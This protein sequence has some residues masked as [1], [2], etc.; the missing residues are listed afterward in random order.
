MKTCP[1]NLEGLFADNAFRWL[2]RNVRQSARWSPS[3]TTGSTIA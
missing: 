1:L 2:A 3:L